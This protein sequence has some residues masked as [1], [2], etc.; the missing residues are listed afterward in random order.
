[1]RKIV[2][3]LLMKFRLQWCENNYK[4]MIKLKVSENIDEKLKEVYKDIISEWD[5]E[6]E[7]KY[8]QRYYI[9][10]KFINI[11]GHPKIKYH[12]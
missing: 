7:I 1:M 10:L 12:H 9:F 4:K 3:I 8:E 2:F 6:E 11:N 5:L